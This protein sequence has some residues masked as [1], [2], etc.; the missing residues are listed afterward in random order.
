MANI[1]NLN[2]DLSWIVRTFGK[3]NLI[4]WIRNRALHVPDAEVAAVAAKF[5]LTVAQW[6]AIET[7]LADQAVKA[8]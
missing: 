7:F 4:P 8:I 5:K 3:S 2:V 1:S 6:R